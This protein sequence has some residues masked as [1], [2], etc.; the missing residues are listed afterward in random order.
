M[1]AY[2]SVLTAQK[3]EVLKVPNAAL[4]FRPAASSMPKRDTEKQERKPLPPGTLRGRVMR[5]VKGELK[6]VPLLL[7]ASDGKFTEVLQGEL[8]AG[9]SVVVEDLQAS[10]GAG[11]VTPPIRF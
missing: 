8:M 3:T 11:K 10:A 5:L 9:D 2:V 7:G 4:R 1:T 6:A